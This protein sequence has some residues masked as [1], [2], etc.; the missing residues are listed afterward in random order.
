[1]WTTPELGYICIYFVDERC[2][3]RLRGD[4]VVNG[5]VGNDDDVGDVVGGNECVCVC[6]QGVSK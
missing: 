3:W 4:G 1:M 6:M 2:C 5:C